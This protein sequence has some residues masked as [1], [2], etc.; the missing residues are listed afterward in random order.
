VRKAVSL[1]SL[2]GIAVLAGLAI[3]LS[4]SVVGGTH[5][6]FNGETQN[7]N[8]K[9]AA[10]WMGAPTAL[11][12]TLKGAD[13]QLNW[14]APTGH[15]TDELVQGYD[16]TTTSSCSSGYAQIADLGSGTTATYADNGRGAGASGVAP[17]GDWYCYEVT[18][19]LTTQWQLNTT[20]AATQVGLAATAA[21][22]TNHGTSNK[23]DNTDTIQLTFNQQTAL[24]TGSTS[25]SICVVKN[26]N[27]NG[28]VLG[29][30][31]CTGS[32][33]TSVANSV[34]TLILSGGP[35]LPST[36][37]CSTSTY[38][39]TSASPFTATFTLAGCGGGVSIGG[40]GTAT[41]TFIPGASTLLSKSGNGTQV[42]ICTQANANCRP[43][44]TSN[45]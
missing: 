29:A 10:D 32:T 19:E 23:V 2:R 42:G 37:N 9:F 31:S 24:N 16:A 1:R 8:S 4:G 30:A 34:G 35:T 39:S 17:D 13:V 27:G 22:I 6:L 11:S 15:P 21:Q 7:A 12:A 20:L 41:W 5:A 40:S 28:I 18:S 25:I 3:V 36:V 43:A 26:A 38:T 45:F 44:T 14:T 33:T